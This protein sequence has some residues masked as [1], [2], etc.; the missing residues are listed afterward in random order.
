MFLR[1]L[2]RS[3]W[4]LYDN[5][6]K[7]IV[8]NVILFA[9][10]LAAFYLLWSNK[11]TVPALFLVGLL[12]HIFTPA[13]I[14]Y[15]IKI[16]RMDDNKGMWG[17][18]WEGLK[19]FWWRGIVIYALLAAMIFLAFIAFNFYKAH[20]S[21]ILA[22]IAGGIG[23]W[24]IISFILMQIYL[25]PIMVMDEKRRI[26]SS[27]KKSVIMLL[28]APFSSIFTAAVMAFF[29][30]LF[31]PVTSALRMGWVVYATMFPIFLMPFLTLVF[32]ILMQLN[33]A[34]LI[35]EKHGVNPPLTEIWEKRD[36]SNLFR[37][38]EV[39]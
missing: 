2:N 7:G 39:K 25:M 26:W 33:S 21:N 18:L 24:A 34:M 3:F 13:V 8:I 35:Y 6:L 23:I 38:W 10:Y 30:M 36:L 32:N 14:H 9:L 15:Y 12:W 29:F 27:Y 1:A 16:I 28:S 19:L 11:M 20:S 31:F 22:L 4:V 37:P 17:E 5:L